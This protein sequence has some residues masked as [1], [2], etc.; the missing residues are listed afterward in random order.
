M[1]IQELRSTFGRQAQKTF[2]LLL[3]IQNRFKLRQIAVA[4]KVEVLENYW[5]KMVGRIMVDAIKKKDNKTIELMKHIMKIKLEVRTHLL[6]E[7]VRRCRQLHAI[8]FMQWRAKFPNELTFH[9]YE[10]ENLIDERINHVYGAK[11]KGK[12]SVV[13]AYGAEKT[14]RFYNDYTY[15]ATKG[16]PFNIQNFE[17]LGWPFPFQE[18]SPLPVFKIPKK[19]DKLVYDPSRYVADASPSLIYIPSRKMM[20]TMMRACIQ[21]ANLSELWVN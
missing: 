19:A 5:N 13:T 17:S 11:L 12:V 4:A 9:K 10:L 2:D 20:M 21:V 6:H 7:F 1:R 8:A 18:E 15:L 16:K 14:F 3:G